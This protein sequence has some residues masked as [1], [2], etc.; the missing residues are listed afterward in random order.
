MLQLTLVLDLAKRCLVAVQGPATP[1]T[2]PNG[3]PL[4][5]AEMRGVA[6]VFLPSAPQEIPNS[7]G[8]GPEI[9]RR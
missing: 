1:G 6:M 7:L 9:P 3:M 5:L 8:I 2:L 4:S